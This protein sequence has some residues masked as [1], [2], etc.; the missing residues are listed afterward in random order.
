M[1]DVNKSDTTPKSSGE[2]SSADSV[3]RK[4]G[5]AIGKIASKVRLSQT[6]REPSS[7]AHENRKYEIKKKKKTAHRRR[8]KGSN[9]NG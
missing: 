2:E 1:A 8:L 3:V 9:T 5:S 4:V 7:N 6:S